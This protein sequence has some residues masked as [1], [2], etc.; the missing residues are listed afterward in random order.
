MFD[1][2]LLTAL[3]AVVKAGS[4]DK[5]AALLCITPSAVSQRIRQL[6]ERT[7]QLLLIRSCVPWG[8]CRES[9]A[10]LR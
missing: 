1:Y 9:T 6:E 4:F 3:E 2:K 8:I 10:T 7:G 5:A